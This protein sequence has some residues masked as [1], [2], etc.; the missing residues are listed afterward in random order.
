MTGSPLG[1]REPRNGG[2]NMAPADGSHPIA[3]LLRSLE[4]LSRLGDRTRRT[5]FV[6]QSA[7]DA[8]KGDHFLFHW[9]RRRICCSTLRV[10]LIGMHPFD[11]E[12]NMFPAFLLFGIFERYE[13][14]L[15][16]SCLRLGS[17]V[18]FLVKQTA[19]HLIYPL[20]LALHGS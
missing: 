17:I 4:L 2:A 15:P 7:R 20:D 9:L 3:P 5:A 14:R 6:E 11:G 16:F 10:L 13:S 19:R 8:V 1:L 12:E 18:A